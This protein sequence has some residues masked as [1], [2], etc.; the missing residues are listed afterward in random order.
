MKKIKKIIIICIVLAFIILFTVNSI[1]NFMI[2]SKLQEKLQDKL[3]ATNMYSRVENIEDN[4]IVELY[5]KDADFKYIVDNGIQRMT[6]YKID[7]IVTRFIDTKLDNRNERIMDVVEDKNNEF[8]YTTMMDYVNNDNVFEKIVNSMVSLIKTENLNGKECLVLINKGAYANYMYSGDLEK[9]KVYIDKE[10]GLPVTAI[11]EYNSG[12]NQRIVNYEYQLGAVTDSDLE[13]PDTSEYKNANVEWQEYPEDMDKKVF[14]WLLGDET[15]AEEYENETMYLLMRKTLYSLSQ[16]YDK[17]EDCPF[18]NI[19]L[20]VLGIGDSTEIVD[21]TSNYAVYCYPNNANNE[22]S[23]KY[24]KIISYDIADF[25]EK[26]KEGYYNLEQ[27]T[28]NQYEL[29][30]KNN[31]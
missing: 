23:T 1:R 27:Q 16:K 25:N 20:S 18:T 11:E 14:L 19:Y 4:V 12:K 3:Y 7:N 13:L 5:K 9:M 31:N 15:A 17:S 6:T 2:I 30:N 21:W 10:T 8:N 29:L 26:Y 22:L 24:T 28:E